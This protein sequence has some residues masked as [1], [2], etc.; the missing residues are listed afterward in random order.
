[1]SRASS[2]EQLATLDSCSRALSPLLASHVTLRPNAIPEKV[3]NPPGPVVASFEF[4]C[5]A[6]LP[7]RA[8]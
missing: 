5:Q 3:G 2:R 6:F 1:M 8:G 4:M 7:V